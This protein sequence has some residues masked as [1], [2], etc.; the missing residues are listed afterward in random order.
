MTS[1][2]HPSLHSH[3]PTLFQILSRGR[4]QRK[5]GAFLC[6]IF[7]QY[8]SLQEN[9]PLTNW[10]LEHHPPLPSSTP[11]QMSPWTLKI[12]KIPHSLIS[13]CLFVLGFCHWNCLLNICKQI[14]LNTKCSR[15]SRFHIRINLLLR[16]RE[17][18]KRST[19]FKSSTWRGWSA[20]AHYTRG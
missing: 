6:I 16:C 8:K 7:L 4:I 10:R 1:G 18:S 15:F 19:V 17:Q 11:L 3:H 14:W 2:E 9:D 13:F 20:C 5:A 12:W